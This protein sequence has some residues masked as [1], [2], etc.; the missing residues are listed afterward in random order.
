[1]KFTDTNNPPLSQAKLHEF[2][3]RLGIALPGD[4]QSFLLSCNGGIPSHTLLHIP[5]CA[6]DALIEVFLG[7]DRPHGDLE[8][9][10]REF[11]DD[12][13][14]D[15]IPI[16]FDP[17]GNA[18]LLSLKNGK[19]YYWDSARHF[20]VSTDEVNA[21]LVGESFTQMLDALRPFP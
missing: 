12:L 1:M 6:D 3:T 13:K 17:G 18:L 20:P 10:I 5:A 11:E 7:V 14:R 2:E 9:W 15:L 19:V 16:A 4:Y 8:E 21:F